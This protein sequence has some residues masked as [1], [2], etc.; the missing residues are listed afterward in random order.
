MSLF[1]IT[2][3]HP[4]AKCFMSGKETQAVEFTRGDDRPVI[5]ALNEFVKLLRLELRKVE[6]AGSTNGDSRESAK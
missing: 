2:R 6:H 5:V 3:M 4:K 1:Q